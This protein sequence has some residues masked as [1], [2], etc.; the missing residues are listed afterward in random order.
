MSDLYA[1]ETIFGNILGIAGFAQWYDQ[2][3]NVYCI[4]EQTLF[5]IFAILIQEN[6][7]TSFAPI[8]LAWA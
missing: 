2:Q 7:M 1:V 8:Q 5:S 3:A 6:Q 4:S